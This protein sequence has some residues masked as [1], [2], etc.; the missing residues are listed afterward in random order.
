M[1]SLYLLL[2]FCLASASA[3]AL[4]ITSA[5]IGTYVLLDKEQKPADQ[6]YR[7]SKPKGKWLVESKAAGKKWK[8]LSCGKSCGFKPSS[9][10]EIRAMFPPGW[11]ANADIA[12]I[13]NATQAFCHYLKKIEE[14]TNGYVFIT[15]DKDQS[16][17]SFLQR[18]TPKS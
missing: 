7:L 8:D 6:H 12:C 3:M 17:P 10:N 9:I 13:Q 1:K 11:S 4:E 5:D 15:I 2:L 14:G 16:K 18:V